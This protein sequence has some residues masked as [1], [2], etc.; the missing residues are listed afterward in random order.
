MI[1]FHLKCTCIP[2]PLAGPLKLFTK[3]SCGW[4]YY[5]HVFG[6]RISVVGVVVLTIAGYMWI[7]CVVPVVDF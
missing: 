6:P 4:H 1:L 5:L 3:S 2:K 7:V